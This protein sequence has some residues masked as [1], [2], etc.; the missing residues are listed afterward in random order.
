MEFQSIRNKVSQYFKKT[1][2]PFGTVQTRKMV[3]YTTFVIFLAETFVM[4]LLEMILDIPEPVVW[5]IDGLLLVLILFPLN[6]FY[7]IQPILKQN[8]DYQKMNLDLMKSNEILERFFDIS[9]FLIAYLDADFNFIRVNK[10]YA[11]SDKKSPEFYVGKN[12]FELFP[13]KENQSIFEE[14]V[15]SGKSFSVVEKLF[16]YPANPERGIS[17]WDWSLIPIKDPD[18]KVIGLIMVLSD[19]TSRKMA[20][21]ALV[22]SE[23][24]FRGV[25][26]QTFQLVGLLTPEGALTLFNQTALDFT[27]V[28]PATIY[29]KHLWEM[30]W[31]KEDQETKKSMQSAIKQAA[32][33]TTIR[34][35]YPITSV[36]GET[37]TMDITIKPLQNNEGQP[38][39][40]IFEARDITDRALT[41]ERLRKNE[42]EIQRLYEAEKQAHTLAEALREAAIDLSRSLISGNVFESLL[43]NIY[44]VVPYDSAHIELL[45]DDDHL[46]VR[47]VR[48]EENWIEEKRLLGK[49][50]DLAEIP[51]FDTLFK[52]NKMVIV[53]DTKYYKGSRYFPG[54]EY[55]GSW[56]AIPLQA[57]GQVIGL[58][59]LEHKTSDFFIPELVDWAVAVI[60]QASVA[61]QNAWLFEQVRDGREQLQALSRQLVEVQELERQYIARE[62]HDEA[63]QTLA[64]LM[65]GLKVMESKSHDPEAVINHSRELKQVADGVLE[66][67]H[68]LSISLRP[69]TLDHLGL[70]PALRQHVEMVKDHHNL[71]VQFEVIGNVDRLPSDMETA[72]YRIV[73]EAL[74]NIVRHANAT[75]ADVI[76]EKTK[77]G[78][79]VIVEDD[80]IG[81]D[82]RKVSAEH[83]GLVG[84]QERATMLGGR[85]T[86]E[87]SPKQG[88]MIKLEVPWQFES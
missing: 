66:N 19:V 29:G 46:I 35:V 6:Y 76:L 65:V 60:N 38:I 87:S 53:Q 57:S 1:I 54:N 13:D 85:I 51:T 25:F 78:I 84:M 32:E 82:P 44:K 41:E 47:N 18:E 49:R 63:G 10:A 79:M 30:P 8:Y 26:N 5:F 58:C 22:E 48:G 37:A 3:V 70:V 17:Y 56:V 86:Y 27:G 11:V 61:I 39:L 9:E 64:S 62:L 33:G 14:V 2:E 16:E 24:R 45:E 77:D 71:N 34:C 36:I 4:V 7:I 74:T 12:H 73:Q 43:D 69:A 23:N 81:F 28:D 83:L 88:S 50:I 75:R 52:Q 68:R 55:I 20:Q 15:K 31:W 80:G 42:E 59:I 72:I 21:D 40:L 67:L